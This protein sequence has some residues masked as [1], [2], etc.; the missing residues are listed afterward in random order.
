MQYSHDPAWSVLSRLEGS[1]D[2]F[3]GCENINIGTPTWET[4]SIHRWEQAIWNSFIKF[5]WFHI[6]LVKCF[7]W[8]IKKLTSSTGHLE[9]TMI[10][11]ASNAVVCAYN[12]LPFVTDLV[13]A[14]DDWCYEVWSPSRV[15]SIKSIQV[16]SDKY[17]KKS[18]WKRM[19]IR[20]SRENLVT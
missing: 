7:A 5:L 18:K 19:I 17:L 8:A 12:W 3:I 11:L 10:R 15:K 6:W 16:F 2:Q 20:F 14:S 9:V 4:I 1:Y 13:E